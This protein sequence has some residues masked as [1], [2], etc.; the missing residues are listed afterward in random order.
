MLIAAVALLTGCPK[1]TPPSEA[2]AVG[3]G[4]APPPSATPPP[5]EKLADE[6]S[7]EEKPAD[8]EGSKVK[9]EGEE[10]K[11]V[12]KTASGLQYVVLDEGTGA[13]PAK[14]EKVIA[15]YTG[16]LT[17]GT[18]FD[19]SKDHPGEFDFNVDEGNVIPGWDEAFAGMKE[20]E[21]RKLIIPA[22][23]GYGEM[24]TPGGPIPPNATLIFEVKL[25]KIVK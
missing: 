22:E 15:E 13:K 3:L 6:K 9:V 16:W 19:S 14:G 10:G 18:K 5:A 25:V 24:G 7:A 20:G 2:P 23:L 11:P 4:E 8:N 1:P 21:R 17:D 12:E